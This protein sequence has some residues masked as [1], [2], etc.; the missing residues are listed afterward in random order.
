MKKLIYGTLFLA[1]LGIGIAGCKKES[2]TPQNPASDINSETQVL[3]KGGVVYANL[4][5]DLPNGQTGCQCTITQSDDDC[6]LQTDCTAQSS[7]PN[8]S[9]ELEAM[10]TQ[11]EIRDRAINRVRITEPE[12]IDALRLDN[13][14]VK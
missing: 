9:H 8:Y 14:P 13:F 7:L 4:S 5:C 1:L 12:L 6:S 10:F 3:K 11:Q 2:I